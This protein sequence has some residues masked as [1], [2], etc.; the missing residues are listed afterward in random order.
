MKNIYL[1]KI[2]RKL[3]TLRFYIDWLVINLWLNWFKSNDWFWFFF[4][5]WD[6]FQ[7]IDDD[8]N[9]LHYRYLTPTTKEGNIFPMVIIDQ[10]KKQILIFPTKP[11][12]NWFGFHIT[13][14]S[15]NSL[16]SKTRH[17]EIQSV[18]ISTITIYHP[19]STFL[20]LILALADYA[21][22]KTHAFGYCEILWLC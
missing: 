6:L 20:E 10:P 21:V 13:S 18:H 17:L 9:D 2:T 7:F 5:R 16:D 4:F 11:L 12:L 1:K 22:D 15:L 3:L 19:S 8:L 14:L